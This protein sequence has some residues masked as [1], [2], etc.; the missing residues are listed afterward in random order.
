MPL[1]V[2]VAWHEPLILGG[3]RMND[4]RVGGTRT[5]AQT[6]N[7]DYDAQSGHVFAI[8]RWG[9]TTAASTW[10]MNI[11]TDGGD[12]WAESYSYANATGLIDV[13]CAVVDDYVYVAY[14]AGAAP[15]EA[16]IRR[17]LTSTGAVDGGYGYH[18][19]FDAGANTVEEVALATNADD[20]D[21]RV[22]YAIIQSDDVLRYAFDSASDGT[23]FAEESPS[24]A[25]A[26]FGLDMTWDH[27]RGECSE[28]LYVSYAGNDGDVHV[29]GHSEAGW[30]DWAVE[31]GAGS[32]R[33]T[34]ISA[35]ADAVICAFEYP[36]NLGPGIRY[37]ISYDCGDTW[38]QGSLAVP[39]GATTFGYFEPDVDA[40]DGHGTAIIYQ[41]E[42]G[43][44]D[45]MY[46]RTRAGFAPG[47]WSDPALFCDH[48]VYTGSETALA[49]LPPLAGEPFAHGA[50]YLSLDPDFRTPYFDRPSAAGAACDDATP[51]IVSIDAPTALACACNLVDITGSVDDPDG[52]YAGDRLEI[53]RR[54]TST[55]TVVESATGARSGVLYTWNTTGLPQ[56]Y[57]SLRV[58]GENEC[59]STASD[60]AFVYVSTGFDELELRSPVD[61]DVYGG[62]VCFD[63]TAWTQS[64]FAEYTASFRPTGGANWYP[65][66]PNYP[67]YTTTVINDPLAVWDTAVLGLPDGV[68]DV[69]LAGETDCGDTSGATIKVTL[70]NTPPT[71][72]LDTPISCAVFAAGARIAF[73]GE[74]YDKNLDEW[75]LAVIGGPYAE[76][77]TLAGPNTANTNGLLFTWDTSG[78]PDCAYTLRLRA[79][80]R[81]AVDGDAGQH[82]ADDVAVILLG[83]WTTGDLNCD[84][85]VNFSDIDPF[86]LAIT[87]PPAYAAAYPDCDP[88]LADCDQDGAVNFGDIEYFVALLVE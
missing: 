24:G 76:W 29:L 81:A 53:R 61:G 34:A 32:F 55:W 44:F 10:T 41:A 33:R 46:Y 68:Y 28:F 17:C 20:Y 2:S 57:Y 86:V 73:Y 74:I 64:C 51:P 49:H 70:D 3:L 6:M 72:R 19:V 12:T 88:L 8:L 1:A 69:R 16:R 50:L 31:P 87:D 26:E 35:Y 22:Y 18:V 11:S 43:E 79:F 42:A 82:V 13:D 60:A 58:V 85:V 59:G 66:D 30:T 7:L 65:V 78:L 5:E 47:A 40:R 80:D 48:D 75:T 39:D 4:A 63:G 37:R 15:D 14:V 38:M 9:S 27:H 45:P 77:H 84:G 36:Y 23:T 25:N 52:A 67:A 21:N 62:W 56:D 83:D 54:G 71:A